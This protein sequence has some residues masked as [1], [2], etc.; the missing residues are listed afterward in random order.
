MRA[1]PILA[2]AVAS[3]C[4]TQVAFADRARA[5]SLY[6]AA[7]AAF[8]KGDYLQAATTFEASYKEEPRTATLYNAALSWESINEPARAA[9]DFAAALKGVD[10]T[11]DLVKQARERLAR[12]DRQV[13]RVQIEGAAGITVQIGPLDGAAVPVELRLTPGHYTVHA[14]TG[15]G[16]SFDKDVDVTAGAQVRVELAPPPA[17]PVATNPVPPPIEVEAPSPGTTGIVGKATLPVGIALSA[18][19]L[20]LTATTIGLGAATLGASD[21]YQA[22]GYRSQDLHDQA[23]SLRTWTNVALVGALV[24]G[25]LGVGALLT[26]H[27][28]KTEITFLPGFVYGKF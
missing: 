17:A 13:G 10:L 8:K 25:A 26:L 16:A 4:A 2:I 9:D 27:K 15:S 18:A 6:H 14:K 20:A 24:T 22:S 23:V 7:E 12:L 21:D 28:Q 11:P 3:I 1:I 19:C 5:A